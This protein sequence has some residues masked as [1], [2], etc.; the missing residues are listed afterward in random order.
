VTRNESVC[1]S[2]SICS[3]N[4]G[5]V[6]GRWLCN[7]DHYWWESAATSCEE[8]LDTCEQLKIAETTKLNDH[9]HAGPPE[10]LFRIAHCA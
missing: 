3:T 5:L 7:C 10:I 1:R 8:L 2:L 4:I 9:C 6:A